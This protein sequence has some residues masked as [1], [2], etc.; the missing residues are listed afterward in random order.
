ML[1]ILCDIRKTFELDC[2]SNLPAY[3][4]KYTDGV[5]EDMS[6]LFAD[7]TTTTTTSSTTTHPTEE[8]AD[9]CQDQQNGQYTHPDCLKYY[10]CTNSITAIQECP[11]GLYFNPLSSYCDYESNMDL[12]RCENEATT[13][14]TSTESTASTTT[15]DPNAEDPDF[16]KSHKDGL[17]KHPN[18]SKYYH[19]YNNGSQVVVKC[20]AGT[21]F[22]PKIKTCDWPYNF[23]CSW[24]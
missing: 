2:R 12:T 6:C 23:T 8:D 4:V 3:A 15:K 21:K 22:N 17:H 14:S 5:H 11:A 24:P 10:L 9:F 16:C 20:P 7:E 1:L 18:C 19:C 13:T